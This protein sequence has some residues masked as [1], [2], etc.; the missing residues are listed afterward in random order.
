LDVVGHDAGLIPVDLYAGI[1]GRNLLKQNA[2][3][4]GASMIVVY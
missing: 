3:F 1:R 4:H 2:D